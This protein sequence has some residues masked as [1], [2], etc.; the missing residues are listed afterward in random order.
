MDGSKNLPFTLLVL[1]CVVSFLLLV[2]L[3]YKA[4]LG[5]IWEALGSANPFWVIIAFLLHIIGFIIS[6]Y[7]WQILLK[8]QSVEVSIGFLIK[9]YLVG[10]FFNNFLPSTVGGDVVRAYDTAQFTKSGTQALTIVMIERLTGMFAL[11]LFAFI[12]LLFGFS[13]FTQIPMVW[14]SLSMLLFAFIVFLGVLHPRVSGFIHALLENSNPRSYS[15][16]NKG[17]DKLKKLFGTLLVYQKNKRIL[18]IAF[19]LAILLQI[20]VVFHF[21]FLSFALNFSVPLLYYFLIIP[22]TTVVL[23]LP[24]FING[25]GAREAIYIFFLSKFQVTSPQAIAFTWITFG[26]VLFQGI[27]GGII[28]ALRR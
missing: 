17:I 14:L 2:Y 11:G 8:A 24:V 15:F 12:A 7:R 19:L 20:N 26:M 9:S 5:L 27:I 6:A 18:G 13:V 3:L 4:D 21:Y 1:R 25:I 23:L 16:L 22:V 28:Y 10:I